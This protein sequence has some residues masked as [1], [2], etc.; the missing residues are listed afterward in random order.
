MENDRREGALLD[1]RNLSVVFPAGSG[2]IKAVD[3]LSL[4]IRRGEISAVVGE[5]GC[6]KS[7]LCR[8]VLGLLPRIAE[9]PSGS[10]RLEGREIL[11][12][13]DRMLTGI[14]G[15]DISMVFQDPM[16][17]LD[18][19]CTV[20]AQIAEAVL[21]HGQ[22]GPA[23]RSSGE[24][25]TRKPEQVHSQGAPAARGSR[26]DAARELE[27]AR[28][29]TDA[30]ARGRRPSTAEVHSRVIELMESVG[31]D[32]AE[33]R[34][35]S[36]PWMLSGGQRQ[37]CVLAMALSQDPLLLIADEPTTA[38]DVTVQTEILDL[39]LQL[40]DRRG[41]SM[42]FISHDLGVVA[43]VA[44]SVHIMNSGQIVERGP[45][46]DVLLRPEHPYTQKLL[47]SLPSLAVEART[48]GETAAATSPAAPAPADPECADAARATTLASSSNSLSDTQATE[49]TDADA[50]VAVAVSG[51][52]ETAKSAPLLR[53]RDVSH[54]FRLGRRSVI[55]AVDGVS[56]DIYPGETLAL[57]GES[58]SGKTTLARCILGMLQPE[59]GSIL[60]DG[61]D[62]ACRGRHRAQ[63]NRHRGNRRPSDNPDDEGSTLTSRHRAGRRSS[64]SS[65]DKGTAFT[66]SARAGMLRGTEAI[67]TR[68]AMLRLSREIQFISQDPGAAL[69]PHMT[70]REIV[71]E[72]L[73]IHRVW[74]NRRDLDNRI[75]SMLR[76]V[77]L[78]EDLMDRYP[79]ELSGGQKQRVSI[80][81]AYIMEPKL[82][83][84]DEPTAS[85]DVSI[86]A[87]IMN[88][89]ATLKEKHD[90]ALLF[91]S[92]DLSLVRLISD[93]VGVMRRGQLVELA[94]T[95]EL[96]RSPAHPYTKTLLSA[97]PIPDPI[98]ERQR[99]M[100][101]YEKASYERNDLTP[102]W[103]EISPGHFA[104]V[105]KEVI[106]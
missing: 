80:A 15:A 71:A 75:R 2:T 13:S 42:L 21:A 94:P 9:V 43:R 7:V 64:G 68:E 61:I 51:I 59:H 3:D 63:A 102:A 69:N 58:G 28:E 90:A 85:L 72:P 11:G 40:R 48:S 14:R 86:Q 47:R 20:G 81:R 66:D 96:F 77:L 65:D 98:R 82:L 55:R 83:V 41:L 79:A 104:R 97:I 37:R 27:T 87:Q 95:E 105:G 54:S 49:E 10:V 36:Y 12:L 101:R 32:H 45:A 78:E 44:D 31:I 50:A 74:K 1:I 103:A 17:S 39:L 84:A 38:L 23:A 33:Q 99:Q 22:R 35:N 106:R 8:T 60:Y 62:L 53:A 18:P 52:P 16:T 70:V 26:K 29:H 34:Y 89:F 19:S 76:E 73:Q 91:I 56:L 88:L 67:T 24:A 5:S 92:H 46:E 100:I 4:S 57:V 6:G 25:V 30:A 93:R